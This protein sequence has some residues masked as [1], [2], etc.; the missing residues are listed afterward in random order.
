MGLEDF[1]GVFFSGVDFRESLIV[2]E[3]NEVGRSVVLSPLAAFQAVPGKVSYFSALEAGVRQVSCGG[4]I[5]LEVVLRAVSLVS[6]GV[7]L[8][9]EVI[10][11]V[12]PSV[13]PSGWCP[14]PV[15]IHWD[16]GVVHPAGSIR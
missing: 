13:V 10:P 9:V 3:V 12:V 6:I 15:Y 2:V 4:H 8:S 1:D 7:L 11:S 14:V 16:R 5:A